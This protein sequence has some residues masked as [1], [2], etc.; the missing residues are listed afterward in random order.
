MEGFDRMVD[1]K[2]KINEYMNRLDSKGYFNGSILVAKK[3]EILLSKG[4]GKSNIEHNVINSPQTKYR[5]GSITKSFTAISILQLKEQGLLNLHDSLDQFLEGF[6][7][8]DKVTVHNLLNHTSGIPNF[9][10]HKDYW[11]KEMRLPKTIGEMLDSYKL[12]PLDFEPGTQ[13][14]YSNS[15]YIILTAIIEKLSGLNY[16]DYLENF[17]LK[18]LNMLDSG[19][20]DGKTVLDNLS[21]GY[22]VWEELI[23]PEFIDMSF[24]LGAF[25]MYSTI[26]D[27]YLFDQALYASN[28]VSNQSI[29][30]MFSPYQH[31]YGYGWA[32]WN[33]NIDPKTELKFTSHF[34]DINGYSNDIVRCMNEQI[35]VIALSNNEIT[36]VMKI[37][38]D[39]LRIVLELP[40]ENMNTYESIE[41]EKQKLIKFVGKYENNKIDKPLMISLKDNQLFITLHKRYQ[42]EFKL[43][44]YPT[45]SREKETAFYTNMINNQV[46]IREIEGTILELHHRNENNETVIFRKELFT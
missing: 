40:T 4:Y 27:L 37:T 22:S 1:T 2:L 3:G 7:F 36:P 12:F 14:K 26:E 34:G 24:P 6:P 23:K 41:M 35:T 38:R 8:G 25:G 39:L 20:D 42:K 15:S 43:K 45:V 5:I 21:S 13:F 17:I 31:G 16:K 11:K 46:L 9:T 28:L 19:C 32:I 18:P 30:E 44:L 29:E 10:D 33:A